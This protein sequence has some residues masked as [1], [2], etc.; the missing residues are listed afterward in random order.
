ML[1]RFGV[2]VMIVVKSQGSRVRRLGSGVLTIDPRIWGQWSKKVGNKKRLSK[3][4][5]YNLF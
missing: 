4:V 2:R 1:V 5:N 3:K